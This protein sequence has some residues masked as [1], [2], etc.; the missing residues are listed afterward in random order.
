MLAAQASQVNAK[1]LRFQSLH[2][3]STCKST[4]GSMVVEAEAGGK[5]LGEAQ[6]GRRHRLNPCALLLNTGSTG[7]F[8]A[9]RANE[10]RTDEGQHLEAERESE[11]VRNQVCVEVVADTNQQ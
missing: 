6:L 5:S 8:F 1:S 9:G 10:P 2:A 11:G 7:E 3:L 4:S